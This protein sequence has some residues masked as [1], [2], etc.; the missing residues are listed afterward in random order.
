MLLLRNLFLTK[1]LNFY[2][3]SS[4]NVYVFEEMYFLLI[5]F[6]RKNEFD[7]YHFTIY[8]H[9]KKIPQLY[10]DPYRELQLIIGA[11]S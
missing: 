1:I 8:I 7:N 9:R 11:K 6:H 2:F 3:G 5:L 4:R 10:Y